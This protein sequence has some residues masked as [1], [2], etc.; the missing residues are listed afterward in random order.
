MISF[1]DQEEKNT[2]K[3]YLNQ[4][5]QRHLVTQQQIK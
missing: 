4:Q 3:E 1:P 5:Q 2:H